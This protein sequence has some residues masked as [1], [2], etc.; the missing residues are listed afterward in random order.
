[1]KKEFLKRIFVYQLNQFKMSIMK[2]ILIVV[3]C[4]II[5]CILIYLYFGGFKRL[6]IQIEEQGGETVVY[7]EIRGD[8]RQSGAV[9]DKIY[10]SLKEKDKIETF[11]GFGFYYDNP[12]K[13]EINKLR[14]EAG[15]I[16]ESPDLDKLLN[17][18][19]NFKSKVL[20][21]KKYIIT[22]FPYKGKISVMFSIMKV[23]PSM[24]K[25]AEE[26]DLD[27]D[28]AV[29]EIYDI[30]NGKILYRKEIVKRDE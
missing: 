10:Y 21:K 5:L 20:P 14:S 19:G 17:L 22:E 28:G 27:S 15:C 13:V 1:M 26:R 30:P 8:Y 6:N 16:I 3:G 18:S 11:K 25:F 23:Y 24:S 2:I 12:K 9:M 4:L 29:T 7:D